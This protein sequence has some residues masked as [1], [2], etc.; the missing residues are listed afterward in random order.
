[1]GLESILT[2]VKRLTYNNN[3]TEA[4]KI[5]AAEILGDD[6]LVKAYDAVL[7]LQN[8]I[9]FFSQELATIRNGID[10]VL[11][12]DLNYHFTEEGYDKIISCL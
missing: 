12:K 2:H 5:I 1:M 4:R 6:N 7:V 3:H 8:H 10:A 11:K 9:G